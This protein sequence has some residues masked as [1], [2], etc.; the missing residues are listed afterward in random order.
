[1][2]IVINTCYGG[3]GV[4]LEGMMRYAEIKGI[5]LYPEESSLGYHTYWT[6]PPESRIPTI[7]GAEFYK[8]D[9]E[10]RKA[11]NKQYTEQTVYDRRI[12]R[13][14]PALVQVVEELGKSA[15]GQ[16]AELTLVEI[17][18]DVEWEIA[19]YDGNEHVAETHRTWS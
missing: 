5:R 6:T 1:M 17:P 2:K 19:E 15:S 4:S 8:L 12:P 11:Y 14:D 10:A 9:I 3:F 18:D 13:N 7:E 16:C